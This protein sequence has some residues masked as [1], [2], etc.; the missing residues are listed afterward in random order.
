MK[1]SRKLVERLYV[2]YNVVTL[3]GA[4]M[5]AHSGLPVFSG[6]NGLWAKFKPKEFG[7]R[8]AFLRNPALVWKWYCWRREIIRRVKPHL[9]HYAL[10]DIAAF[11]PEFTLITQNADNLQQRAG[12]RNL[13]QLHGNIMRNRCIN[14]TCNVSEEALKKVVATNGINPSRCPQCGSAVRTG[15]LWIDE[16]IPTAAIN[17]AQEA[18]AAAEVFI[19]IGTSSS[20]EPAASLPYLAKGNGAYLVEINPEKTPLSDVADEHITAGAQDVLPML[21]VVLEKIRKRVK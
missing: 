5:N 20:T 7:T 19:A 8:E 16:E 13:I 21:L 17:A 15:I 11:F 10:V 18:T 9:G 2:A 12:S 4:G 14:N 6:E 3:T 1:F